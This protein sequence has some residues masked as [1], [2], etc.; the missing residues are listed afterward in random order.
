MPTSLLVGF[1]SAWT[2]NNSGAIAGLILGN[3]SSVHEIGLPEIVNYSEAERLIL[4]WQRQH[5][6]DRTL[7]LLDQPTIVVNPAGQRPVEGIVS[8]LVSRRLGGMQPAN[9]S[10]AE[11]FGE[12]APVWPFLRRFGGAADP[13]RLSGEAHVIETYPVL[14]LI[15]LGWLLPGRGGCGALPKYNPQR[16]KTFLLDDWKFVCESASRFFA[17][18]SAPELAA[19]LTEAANKPEPRKSDQDRLDAC[20]CLIVAMWLHQ[21]RECLMTGNTASG[22]IVVPHEASVLSEMAVRCQK[23]GLSPGEWTKVFRMG[24][25]RAVEPKNPLAPPV[26]PVPPR[27]STSAPAV[28]TLPKI[29]T[30]LNQHHQRATY[31]AVAGLLGVL[32][33]GV[34]NGRSKSPEYSWIVAA[35]GPEKGRPTGYETGQIHP[36]CLRQIREN[37]GRVITTPDELRQ[38][39]LSLPVTSQPCPPKP[40]CSSA[41]E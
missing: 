39:L 6:P 28:W 26:A 9:Q 25:L 31:G 33:R 19:W 14:T 23:T 24:D 16:T 41:P 7:I 32:P 11:M 21:G 8:S 36:E 2:P 13:L 27:P 15:A 35:S 37:R 29:A 34:M 30:L 4:D 38:W 18:H 10:R 3:D 40:P 17:S 5:A 20:L 12:A 1:D 22:Y